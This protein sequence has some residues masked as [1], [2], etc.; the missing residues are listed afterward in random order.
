MTEKLENQEN[1]E[2]TINQM[3]TDYKK[4]INVHKQATSVVNKNVNNKFKDQRK[5]IKEKQYV[6]N[7]IDE[8][9]L[10]LT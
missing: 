9:P 7:L 10:A 1:P 5:S 2:E 4:S 6:C 8:I 3:I